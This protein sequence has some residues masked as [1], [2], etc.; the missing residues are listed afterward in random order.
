MASVSDLRRIT[1]QERLRSDHIAL[2]EMLQTSVSE[3]ES[4][5]AEL[6]KLKARG[7]AVAVS[8]AEVD[9]AA[10]AIPS[11]APAPSVE[12]TASMVQRILAQEATIKDLKE[13]VKVLTGKLS[14][15]SIEIRNLKKSSS[16]NESLRRDLDNLLAAQ[17]LRDQQDAETASSLGD[18]N[19]KLKDYQALEQAMSK[20]SSEHDSLKT[21]SQ[22]TEMS[23]RTRVQELEQLGETRSQ[24]L[25]AAQSDAT[26]KAVRISA[27]ELTIKELSRVKEDMEQVWRDKYHAESLAGERGKAALVELSDARAREAKLQQALVAMQ[28]ELQAATAAAAAASI[29]AK[30]ASITNSSSSGNE[31]IKPNP[32]LDV[33]ASSAFLTSE[34]QQHQP[35]TDSS[36]QVASGGLFEEFIRLKRE[37]KLLKLELASSR[38]PKPVPVDHLASSS[39]T[40]QLSQLSKQPISQP[41]PRRR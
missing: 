37:N 10:P 6:A 15:A 34:L 1:T 23:L 21:S 38:G 5:K 12:S 31:G 35:R 2:M 20:L 13:E 26:V 19:G 7:Q 4:L 11:T 32:I 24:D 17:K 3:N 36:E 25:L 33:P 22:S 40:S 18:L 14:S 28:A 39:S 16:A 27:L 29:V 41:A 8:A 30:N 9:D